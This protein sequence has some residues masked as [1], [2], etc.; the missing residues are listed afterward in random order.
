MPIPT[1]ACESRLR[2]GTLGGWSVGEV[3]ENLLALRLVL[4]QVAELTTP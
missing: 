3:M 4:G 1:R 2:G